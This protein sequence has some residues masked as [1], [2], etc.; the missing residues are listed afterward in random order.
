MTRHPTLRPTEDEM[1]TMLSFSPSYD[2]VRYAAAREMIDL[3]V[4][5][6]ETSLGCPVDRASLRQVNTSLYEV[7]WLLEG[8]VADVDADT[9][10]RLQSV[11]NDLGGH[12]LA[13]A[14][15]QSI[16]VPAD[17]VATVL[18]RGVVAARC[19]IATIDADGPT[20]T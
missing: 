6:A 10:Q 20:V 19:G 3:R 5:A 12:L 18:R 13:A 2:R 11:R 14:A 15:L 4:E 7:S 1:T 9:A 17:R 8:L 16:D